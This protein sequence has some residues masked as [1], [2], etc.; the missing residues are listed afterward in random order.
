MSEYGTP[1]YPA[2]PSNY[3]V[4][5][6]IDPPD[7]G[8][9]PPVS[10]GYTA[11]QTYD[12]SGQAPA[13]G[14]PSTAD[15]S[16][17]TADGSPS[18]ADVAKDQAANVKDSAVDAGQQVAEVA[19]GQAGEVVAET[20]RQAR[21]LLDQT[22]SELSDQAGA[23]QQRLAAGLHSLADELHAMTKHDSEQG[24]ATDLARQGADRGHQIASWLEDRQPG[25]VFGDLKSFARQRP[26]TFLLAAA[27]V[28]LLAGRLTRGVKDAS[29][30]DS[31]A[32]SV[33]RT[34]SAD[35]NP[36]PLPPVTPTAVDAPVIAEP[37]G[38]PFA[39]SQD[40]SIGGF[41]AGGTL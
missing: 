9:T 10:T 15:G 24:V 12:V 27:G 16:P 23:Q 8:G 18:T 20:G 26:G 25:D 28:G 6:V 19:K 41:P 33:S 21:D 13:D 29:G 39:T 3:E 2:S 1:G 30:D 35:L 17:S 31:G 11:P 36:Q 5:A 37:A 7:L 32:T 34:P 38:R 4:D 22:R 14:S 40:E